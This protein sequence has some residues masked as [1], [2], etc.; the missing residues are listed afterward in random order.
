MVEVRIQILLKP[1]IEINFNGKAIQF[2]CGETKEPRSWAKE[3]TPHL[4][5]YSF[6]SNLVGIIS[7]GK[8]SLVLR[9]GHDPIETLHKSNDEKENPNDKN[10]PTSFL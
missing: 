5:H 1:N 7:L 3:L 6:T 2:L 9:H 10:N 8:F 4:K